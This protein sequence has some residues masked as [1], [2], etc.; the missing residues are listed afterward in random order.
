MMVSFVTGGLFW[1]FLLSAVVAVYRAIVGSTRAPRWT[2][3]AGR[4]AG[5][6]ALGWLLV[7]L[8]FGDS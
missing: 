2:A 1:V 4:L 6:S 8:F 5:L 3:P 7:V